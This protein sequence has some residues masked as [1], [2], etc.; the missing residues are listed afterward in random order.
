VIDSTVVDRRESETAVAGVPRALP[1]GR[2]PDPRQAGATS[3][4]DDER[5]LAETAQ[6]E[7]IHETLDGRHGAVGHSTLTVTVAGGAP[8]RSWPLGVDQIIGRAAG[9][10][11]IVVSDPQVSRRHARISWEGGHFVYRDLGPMNPTRHHGRTLPNPYILRDGDRL[12][13]GK[14][15]LVFRA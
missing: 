4:L 11:V 2:R 14:S 1:G 15:V 7:M 9:P 10:G 13:V 12:N 3:P 8:P 6:V 5:R